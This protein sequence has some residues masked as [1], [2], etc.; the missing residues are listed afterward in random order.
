MIVA[1]CF[2]VFRGEITAG[3][4]MAAMMLAGRAFAPL[5]QMAAL[6]ARLHQ[7]AVAYR[8]LDAVMTAPQDR[9][10][11]AA[12]VTRDACAGGIEFRDVSFAYDPERGEVLRGVSLRIAPGE[13]VGLIGGI[14]SGKS[15]A[16][17][18]VMG[19]HRPTGGAVFLDDLRLSQ[20]DPAWLRARCGYAPQEA[21]LF[22]GTIRSNLTLHVAG[23]R[24][25]DESLL[26][27]V[28]TAGL[29]WVLGLPRGLDTPV[30]E[31]GAGLSTGQRRGVVL[32][33]ALVHRPSLLL[34]DEPTAELDGRSERAFVER[35]GA[36]LDGRTLLAVTHRPALLDLVDRLVVFEGGRVIA[37]GPKAA[38]LE[39]LRG[40]D[41]S[42]PAHA[43]TLDAAA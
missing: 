30:G 39:R 40:L 5:G 18:L 42:R 15:T 35:L 11:G 26:A 17:K 25:D 19:L 21:V 2:L 12:Y 38:V 24:P 9:E 8:L 28:R 29:D 43:P 14:G 36:A 32:A 1:G 20:L 6:L 4:L 37:D 22:H 33:R 23:G 34:L 13:R 16:L 10:I 27:A 31:G 3:A 41:R 7:V